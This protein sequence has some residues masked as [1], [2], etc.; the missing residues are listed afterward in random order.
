MSATSPAPTS[1]P[2]AERTTYRIE[3]DHVE[4][5]NCRHGC[6]CQFGGFPNEGKCESIIGYHIRGGGYGNVDLAGTK[7]VVAMKYPGAI[8]EG[9]GRCVL[10]VGEGASPEQ[11]KAIDEIWSGR[12]GGMP[13]EALAG[14]LDSREGPLVRPIE[15]KIDGTRSSFEIPGVLELE[16]TPL[17]NPVSGEEKEV[18]IRYPKGGFFWNQADCSTTARMRVQ[19]GD[20]AFS[21]P[22]NYASAAVAEWSNEA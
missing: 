21:Y 2:T 12:A 1:A 8:H 18:Q 15:M 13:W 3:M 17:I 7:V 9:N 14:T 22:G 10:F 16:L 4:A 6:N 19:H 5:C 20:L 11:V